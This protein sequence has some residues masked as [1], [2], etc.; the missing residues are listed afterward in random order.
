MIP[1]ENLARINNRQCG[2]PLTDAPALRATTTK[3]RQYGVKRTE[4]SSLPCF[5]VKRRSWLEMYSSRPTPPLAS[6]GTVTASQAGGVKSEP[7]SADPDQTSE[8]VIKAEVEPTTS[9][10]V[11]QVSDD[12]NPSHPVAETHRAQR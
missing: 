7:P 10:E 9:G 8:A 4:V 6:V 2:D 5:H 12:E 11:I 3:Q 1:L